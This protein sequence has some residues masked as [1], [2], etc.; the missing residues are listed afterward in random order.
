MKIIV[1]FT[2]TDGR[3]EAYQEFDNETDAQEFYDAC[4]DSR[5]FTNV[6][7]VRTK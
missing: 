6:T 3:G 7:I 2:L 1:K 4:V 5:H